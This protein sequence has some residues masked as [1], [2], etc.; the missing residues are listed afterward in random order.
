MLFRSICGGSDDGAADYF[1]VYSFAETGDGESN[2]RGSQRIGHR[3]RM[4]YRESNDGIRAAD[5]RK[6][7]KEI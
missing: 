7:M 5:G 3:K 2:G 4:R 6:A 1:S